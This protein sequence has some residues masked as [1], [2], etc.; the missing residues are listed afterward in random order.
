METGV[1][2]ED[3]EFWQAKIDA[4]PEE[5]QRKVMQSFSKQSNNV[6]VPALLCMQHSRLGTDRLYVPSIYYDKCRI[7]WRLFIR[8]ALGDVEILKELRK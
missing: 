2:L 4:L 6:R 1:M 5:W 3:G 7:D 8:H